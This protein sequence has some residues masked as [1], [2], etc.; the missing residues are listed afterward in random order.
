MGHEIEPTPATF[1]YYY[2][3]FSLSSLI[4]FRDLGLNDLIE[5]PPDI[6][7][8]LTLLE[9]MYVL[10]LVAETFFLFLH[11][12]WPARCLCSMDELEQLIF[13]NLAMYRSSAAS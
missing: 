4:A 10:S 11:S 5:L 9:K 3:Y 1:F 6:F 12:P 2:F 13:L 7:D 8:S